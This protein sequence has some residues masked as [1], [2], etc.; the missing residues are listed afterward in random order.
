MGAAVKQDIMRYTI[1]QIYNWLDKAGAPAWIL[2]QCDEA[3]IDRWNPREQPD[4]D[5]DDFDEDDGD[6]KPG[7]API[8][9]EHQYNAIEEHTKGWT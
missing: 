9:S 4:D 3:H 5:D 6:C 2:M 7:A 8:A 1:D